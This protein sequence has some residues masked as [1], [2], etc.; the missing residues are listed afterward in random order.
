MQGPFLPDTLSSD[1]PLPMQVDN[2]GMAMVVQKIF[3]GGDHSFLL[4]KYLEVSYVD[5]HIV[6]TTV[7][8]L[9]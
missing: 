3:T 2:E 5:M 6:A 8:S 7:D 9:T 1:N 4:Y